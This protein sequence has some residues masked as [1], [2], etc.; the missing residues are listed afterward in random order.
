MAF[1]KRR[2]DRRLADRQPVQCAI[3]L[4]LVDHPESELLA[5]A[6]GR[7]VRRQRPGGGKLGPG[8][9]D[10]ADHQGQNE[11]AAAVAVWA[12]QPI[13]ADLARRAEGR[14]DMTMRQRA[15]DGNGILVLGNDGAAFEQC[16]E[17]GDPLLRPVGEVQQRAL[18]DLASLAVALAQQ[19]GRGRVAIGDRFDI[20]GSMIT[21]APRLTIK[22]YPITWLRFRPSKQ[23]RRRY[24]LLDG[25][26]RGK[27]RLASTRLSRVVAPRGPRVRIPLAPAAR[28]SANH[29]FRRRFYGES[30][31]PECVGSRA[32]VQ[33]YRP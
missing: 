20:H 19:D 14:V 9:E 17:A 26:E 29:R 4:V 18:L 7:R 23:L 28:Q 24:Q 22:I 8:I 21:T 1:G 32:L 3:E 25:A 31:R 15:D 10:A 33:R 16:L 27:L 6:G 11:V 30:D 12:E 13:E 5:E 2:L